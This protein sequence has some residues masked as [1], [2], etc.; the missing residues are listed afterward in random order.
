MSGFRGRPPYGYRLERDAGGA[1][2][3]HR[4]VPDEPAATTVRRVFDDYAAGKGLA[5]IAVELTADGIAPPAARLGGR[6]PYPSVW[7]KGTVRS[8]LVNPRY[9]GEPVEGKAGQPVA[10]LV[11]AEVVERV[12]AIFAG[13]SS[14]QPPGRAASPGRYLLRGLIRC[15]HCNRLMQGT[16]NN[17]EPYYR[18]RL[19]AE[20]AA[21]RRPGQPS[22]DHPRNVYLRE[23]RVVDLLRSWLPTTGAVPPSGQ[24]GAP[25]ASTELYRALG[26]GLRYSASD[27]TLYL[28]IVLGPQRR[29]VSGALPV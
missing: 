16:W 22:G 18:C 4:L 6:A 2:G 20:L 24:R 13:R 26:L 25:T 29:V 14:E 7:S 19:P 11:P 12:R 27:G 3:G 28:K 1:G 21:G 5:R 15:A 10:A 23:G 9:T 17:S 8:I